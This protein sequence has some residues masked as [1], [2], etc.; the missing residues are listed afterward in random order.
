MTEIVIN[1]KREVTIES[2]KLLKELI[3]DVF[4]L[5]DRRSNS[6]ISVKVNGNDLDFKDYDLLSSRVDVIGEISFITKSKSTLV[7]SALSSC[8][9]YIDV[10]CEKVNI[11]CELYARNMIHDASVHM[12]ELV[13]TMDFFVRTMSQIKN[14]V[15][16]LSKERFELLMAEHSNIEI[17]LI[18]LLKSLLVAQQTQDI[19]MVTDLLEYEL[20]DNLNVWK[21]K[22][23]PQIEGLVIT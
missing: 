9:E 7:C 13:D 10:A 17:H 3:I 4:A 5:E 23:I 15:R 6:V 21:E 2:D 22:V 20:K 12:T 19:V 11:I 14:T 1:G 16:S 8:R 18:S